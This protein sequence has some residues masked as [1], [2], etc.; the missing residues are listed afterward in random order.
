MPTSVDDLASAIKRDRRTTTELLE[1]L[2]TKGSAVR[3]ERSGAWLH[4]SALDEGRTK[5]DAG[6]ASWFEQNPQ[7]VKA[8]VLEVRRASG[9]EQAVFQFVL[10]AAAK[11]GAL[12]LDGAD[13][14]PAG[15]RVESDPETEAVHARLLEAGLQPPSPAELGA[16]FGGEKAVRAKLGRLV[17]LGRAVRVG[18]EMYFA[19]EAFDRAREAVVANCRKNG[20]LDLPSLRDEVATTRKWLIPLLEHLD[21]IGV[22]MRQGGHR[23]LRGR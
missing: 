17:D 11:D 19:A 6:V 5:L 1:G 7:R 12:T 14:V 4:R 3:T 16:T 13:L 22:T 8:P 15:R 2:A 9:L 20:H 21:A 10:D 23:V 18:P